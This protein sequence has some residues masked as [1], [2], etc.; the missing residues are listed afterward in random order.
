[1][2]ETLSPEQRDVLLLRIF[3]DLTIEQV[4]HLMGKRVER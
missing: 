1:M 4:A 2:I 3:A